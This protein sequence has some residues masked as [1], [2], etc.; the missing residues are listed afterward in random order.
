MVLNDDYC[1]CGGEVL[2]GGDGGDCLVEVVHDGEPGGVLVAAMV[3]QGDDEMV[4]CGGMVVGEGP[5][6]VEVGCWSGRR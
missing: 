3:V 1:C 6:Y 5:V 2:K 4:Q